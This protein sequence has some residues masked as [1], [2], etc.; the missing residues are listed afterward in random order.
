[1][2]SPTKN[3]CKKYC[4]SGAILFIISFLVIAG[5]IFWSIWNKTTAPADAARETITLIHAGDY[6]AAYATTST[7]FQSNVIHEDFIAY[8]DST[9]TITTPAEIKFTYR[10]IEDG[11]AVVSG[12]L[13][14]ETNL[15]PITVQLQ[16]EAGE[17]QAI[18]ISI[19]PEDI[20]ED[21]Q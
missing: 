21:I 16:K 4:A 2:K 14:S 6:N 15:T 13:K 20:P 8:L 19:N 1:M 18:Y 17:W 5:L 9:P 10:Y 3:W 11:F 7:E 12:T